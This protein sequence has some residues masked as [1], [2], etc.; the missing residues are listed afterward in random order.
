MLDP[1]WPADLPAIGGDRLRQWV[2]A[3]SAAMTI[4]PVT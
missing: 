1:S 4:G 2:A 3:T